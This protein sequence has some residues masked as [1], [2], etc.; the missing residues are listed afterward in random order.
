MSADGP[1]AGAAGV[2]AAGGADR[3]MKL[4]I[5]GPNFFDYLGRLAARFGTRGVAA[6]YFD[7]RPANDTRTKI[8]LRFAPRAAKE[9]L[10][11]D[12][13]RALTA[14][15]LDGGFTHVLFVAI[16][17]YPAA[18]IRRLEAAGLHLAG[19]CWDSLANKPHM[20]AIR[21][22]MAAM[23]SFDPEDCARLGFDYIPLYSDAI[24]QVP[25]GPRDIDFF[26]C[27]SFHSQ[28]PVWVDRLIRAADRHGWRL[29]LRLFYHARWLWLVSNAAR[30]RLWYLRHR[31]RTAPWPKP[32]VDAA[33][34]RAKVVI[35]IHHKAQTGLTMR[36]FE[37]L[38]QGAVVLTTNAHALDAVP[39]GLGARI[40]WLDPADVDGAMATALARP[41]GPLGPEARHA[42]SVERFMDDLLGLLNS[43]S[44]AT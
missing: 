10:T 32:E 11:R 35:D 15:I 16:E 38:S 21:P 4:A 36:T 2:P 22:L 42:L 24:A 12:F 7:E 6:A 40:V 23:A 20:G 17:A 30:P 18:E 26:Y 29:E 44:A 43:P 28:R 33:S 14:A 39:E 19:Y 9:R 8:L 27:A 41:S 5:V 1:A 34:E 37:A 3:P 31:F 25:D 13:H